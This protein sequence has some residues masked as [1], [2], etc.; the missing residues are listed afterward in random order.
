M[1]AQKAQIHFNRRTGYILSWELDWSV[2][3][4]GTLLLG[5]LV[6]QVDDVSLRNLLPAFLS[7]V[8]HCE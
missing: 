6:V 7:D 5:I 8:V 2:W 4:I 1:V 3:D